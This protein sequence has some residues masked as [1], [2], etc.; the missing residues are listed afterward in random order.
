M[1][2]K[3][4]YAE[5]LKD[6]RWIK[7]R[8]EILIR[9]KNTCQGCGCKDKYL[10]VHH[11]RYINGLKPWEYDDD[12]LITLCEECHQYETNSAKELYQDYVYFCNAARESGFSNSSISLILNKFSLFFETFNCEDFPCRQNINDIV[13]YAAIS[14]FNYDDLKTL[15]LYGIRCDDWVKEKFPMFLEDYKNVVAKKNMKV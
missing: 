12:E 6:P 11:K 9:D 8:N 10:H 2:E 7:R 1:K 5:L 3:A 4:N 13:E 15:A 14:S